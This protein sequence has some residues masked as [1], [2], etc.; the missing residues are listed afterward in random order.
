VRITIELMITYDLCGV[1]LIVQN[2]DTRLANVLISVKETAIDMP[3]A[4]SHYQHPVPPPKSGSPPKFALT[5][6]ALCAGLALSL[7]EQGTRQQP[8]RVYKAISHPCHREAHL[9]CSLSRRFQN[10]DP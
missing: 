10:S 5:G 6:P 2:S 8:L 3:V 7:H 1:S 4:Q 9:A